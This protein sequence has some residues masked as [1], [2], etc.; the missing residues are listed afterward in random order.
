MRDLAVEVRAVGNTAA[1]GDE[2]VAEGGGQGR[3]A[4]V[5]AGGAVTDIV[6]AR[7]VV[8]ARRRD[9]RRVART[10]DRAGKG[11]ARRVGAERTEDDG[12]AVV[13][14]GG[15]LVA[16]TDVVEV[17]EVGPREHGVIG[18]EHSSARVGDAGVEVVDGA[19]TDLGGDRSAKDRVVGFARC[20]EDA[21]RGALLTGS[22]GRREHVPGGDEPGHGAKVGLLGSARLGRDPE[23]GI[24]ALA[25]PVVG[26]RS[27]PAL[28]DSRG[29]REHVA[30]EVEPGH[31]AK[32]GLLGSARLGRDP[33]H[34]IDALAGPVEGARS[35]APLTDGRGRRKHVARGDESAHGA[36]VGLLGSAGLR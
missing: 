3:D 31:G 15:Q 9:H 25:R 4:R 17:A 13:D 27:G 16:E 18:R 1:L 22:R 26:A 33:E 23:H 11:V 7:E 14:E 28:T 12:A 21:R 2:D 5:D 6:R 24:N 10:H 20:V 36:K 30:G 29:R 32:V 19:A 8:G 35:G 34:G